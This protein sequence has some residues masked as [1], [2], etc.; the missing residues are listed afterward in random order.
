MKESKKFDKNWI[1]VILLILG[2]PIGGLVAG[3]CKY[4][5]GLGILWGMSISFLLGSLIRVAIMLIEKRK[6]EE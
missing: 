5:I 2:V 4:N 6:N 3:I 1:G